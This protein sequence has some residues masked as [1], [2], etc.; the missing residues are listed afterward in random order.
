VSRFLATAP[1]ELVAELERRQATIEVSWRENQRAFART[2]SPEGGLFARYSEDPADAP[3]FEHETA[4][5]AVVGAAGALRTPPVIAEGRGWRIE[6]AINAMEP[7]AGPA[8]VDA[9]VAAAA[10]IPALVLPEAPR[11]AGGAWRLDALL[12]IARA[13]FG[14][15]AFGD[16]RAARRMLAETELPTVTCHRDFH[17]KNILVDDGGVWV[18]DWERASFGPEGLDLMR[19]WTSLAEPE[20]RER[21]FEHAVELAGQGRRHDLERLRFAVAVAE[22][23]G[24]H[25]AR[26]PFDRDDAALARLVELIPSLRPR[27]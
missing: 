18:I 10:E 15:I 4:V 1:A 6:Q 11:D 2:K 23:S 14:P 12:R 21:I 25:T 7:W 3:R 22:A 8:A 5:R 24:L 20:D 27:R 19:L 9:A 16:L 13:A 17:P 26:N